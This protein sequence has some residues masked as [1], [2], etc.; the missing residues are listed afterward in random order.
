[1]ERPKRGLSAFSKK[2]AGLA[3]DVGFGG[4]ALVVERV[5]VL[6]QTRVGGDFDRETDP[7]GLLNPGKTIFREDATFDFTT[8]NSFLFPGL[9]ARALAAQI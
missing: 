6:L 1:M 5:E 3:L 7:E 2:G 8:G 9:E 4:L